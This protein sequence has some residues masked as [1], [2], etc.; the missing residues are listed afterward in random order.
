[1]AKMKNVFRGAYERANKIKFQLV[2]HKDAAT[3]PDF[4][5]FVATI[6]STRSLLAMS[7]SVCTDDASILW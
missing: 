3:Y 5:A 1:M 4:E 7:L 2:V 6:E